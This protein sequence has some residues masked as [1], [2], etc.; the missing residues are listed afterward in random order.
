QRF[1]RHARVRY[2][3]GLPGHSSHVHALRPGARH[4][5]ARRIQTSPEL[6]MAEER[7]IRLINYIAYGSGEVMGAGPNPVMS[8]WIVYFYTTFCGL[9][10]IQAT[11]IFGIA[12]ILDAVWS[13]LIGHVSDN[14]GNTW[15]GRV[16]GRRRFFLLAALPLLPSFA[17]MWVS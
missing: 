3:A 4:I 15:I 7:K 16:F 5:G 2:A 17:A 14:L 10:P 11:G 8:I 9:S 13:P 1:L 6:N 12:R